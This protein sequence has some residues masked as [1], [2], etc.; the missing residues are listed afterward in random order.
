MRQSYGDYCPI[1]LGA[2]IFAERW[3]PLIVRNLHLGARTF[4]DIHGGVP[5]MSRTLLAQRL[6]SLE[7]NGIVER[8]PRAR[9]R[10]WLY[11]LTPAGLELADVCLALGSWGARWLDVA[12]RDADPAVVLWA[13]CHSIDR[14]R[15]PRR[16]V[17]VRFEVAG[18][19]ERRC[20]MLLHPDEVELCIRPPGLDEDLVV[21]TDVETLAG[22][23]TGRLPI[24]DAMR[25]D[26]CTVIGQADLVHAFP[27][28]G[29]VSPFAGVAAA[30][31]PAAG[32]PHAR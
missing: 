1:A 7:R 26:R 15:L 5:R 3:T 8:R 12:P 24:A 29:G 32:G 19:R 6:A 23:E 30:T 20:W 25:T 10:G 27:G 13:W 16:R 31:R 11:T 18:W 17:V 14:A 9:G 22:M 4:T 21:T 2:E 28:W